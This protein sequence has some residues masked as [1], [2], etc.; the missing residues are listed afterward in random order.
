M[1]DDAQV[2]HLDPGYPGLRVPGAGGQAAE[3]PGGQPQLRGH[4]T[5]ARVPGN[6]APGAALSSAPQAITLYKLFESK[7]VLN[8]RGTWYFLR[9]TWYFAQNR[10]LVVMAGSGEAQKPYF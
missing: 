9:G 6:D 7:V 3:H 8:V 10:M 4:V 2:L 5:A 1:T